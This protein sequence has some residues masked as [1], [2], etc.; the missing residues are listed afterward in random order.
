MPTAATPVIGIA[1]DI[2]PSARNGRLYAKAYLNYAEAIWRAGGWPRLIA[3]LPEPDY[4]TA[5]T[6][7]L[8]G[9]LIPGGDDLDPSPYGQPFKPS[10]RFAPVRPERLRFDEMLLSAAL[11]YG[12]PILGVCYGAQLLALLRGGTLIQDIPDERPEAGAHD[13][14]DPKLEQRHALDIAAGSWLEEVFEGVEGE[15]NSVH[16]QAISDPGKGLVVTARAPDG[17]VEAI[18]SDSPDRSWLGIQWHPERA[19]PGPA[20]DGLIAAFVR[21]CDAFRERRGG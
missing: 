7:E 15:V 16:H 21:D 1:T 4:I 6:V 8:D 5:L 18:E 13:S 11:S 20:G 2:E 14:G 17:I 12:L 3:P 19:G 9:L 10:E